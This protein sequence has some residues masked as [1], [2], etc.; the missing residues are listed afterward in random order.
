MV[1]PG[2]TLSYIRLCLS[3]LERQILLLALEKQTAMCKKACE[4]AL[5]QRTM[6][7]L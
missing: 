5:W 4:R 2:V 6:G 3:R 7:G 1:T